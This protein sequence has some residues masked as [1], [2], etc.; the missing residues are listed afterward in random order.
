M[1]LPGAGLFAL[2]QHAGIVPKSIVGQN[3]VGNELLRFLEKYVDVTNPIRDKA[4]EAVSG[5]DKIQDRAK[6]AISGIVGNYSDT[7]LGNGG[8]ASSQTA[9]DLMDFKDTLDKGTGGATTG[10]TPLVNKGRDFIGSKSR[11]DDGGSFIN[12]VVGRA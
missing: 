12:R 2:L 5:S 7:P 4:L 6:E 11:P 1:A 3:D 9:A 8:N 10:I